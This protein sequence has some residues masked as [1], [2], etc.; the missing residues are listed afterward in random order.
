MYC[1]SGRRT[2]I[3]SSADLYAG[4]VPI[5]DVE[6][7]TDEDPRPGLA[8]ALADRIGQVLEAAPGATWVR[9]RTLPSRMYAESGSRVSAEVSPAFVTI[10]AA[11]QPAPGHRAQL[12][13]GIAG[14]VAEVT[15]HPK[16]NVH[17]LFEPDAASRIAFGGHPV[18]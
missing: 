11:R 4:H 6:L 12:F 1:R 16:D 3:R 8:S 18:D 5:V 17:V 9:L 14:A 13:E 7:V 15:G 10:I 2:P